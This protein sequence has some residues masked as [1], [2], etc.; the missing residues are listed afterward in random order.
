MC[1]TRRSALVQLGSLVVAAGCAPTAQSS[2]TETLEPTPSLGAGPYHPVDTNVERDADLTRLTGHSQ[3]ATGQ[4][5]EV[6]G[7][8]LNS[9][10]QPVAGARLELWQ[11]NAVGRY[12]HP[13]HTLPVPLDPNFLG[14]AQLTTAADG[15]F[16]ITS[17]K[18]GQYPDDDGWRAPHIHWTVEAG[19][20]RLTTQMVFPGEP[21]NESDFVLRRTRDPRPLIAREAVAR[22]P[23]ALGFE[24][25]IILPA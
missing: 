15:S 19:E 21:R 16:A 2:E 18:P 11:A 4:I 6:R 13:D 10:G 9:R 14:Y 25:D 5:I 17:I 12:V 3:R 24:W 22:E 1:T 7:R 23:G 20:A 8:V